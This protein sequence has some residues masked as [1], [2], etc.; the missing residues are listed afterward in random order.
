MSKPNAEFRLTPSLA[1]AAERAAAARGVS[2]NQFVNM[3]VVEKLSAIETETYFRKR[4]GKSDR[5]AF[6]RFLDEAGEGA[7]MAGDEMPSA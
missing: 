4:A 7:P 1:A 3:A 5:E 6:M 2:L